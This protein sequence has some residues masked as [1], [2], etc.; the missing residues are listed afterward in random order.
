[1]I[2]PHSGLEIDQNLKDGSSHSCKTFNNEPLS[3]KKHFKLQNIE[4]WALTDLD[5]R[6]N[7]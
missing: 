1:M 6:N 7:V 3:K 5:W 2:S 4:V